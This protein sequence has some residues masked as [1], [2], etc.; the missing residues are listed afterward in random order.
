MIIEIQV[1]P[2]PGGTSD[3]R[4][5]NVHA[6]ITV[7]EE[8]GLHYEVGPLG[9]SIEGSPDELWPLLRKVHEAPLEAGAQGCISVVKIA[10]HHDDDAPTM[11]SLTDR[12]RS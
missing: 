12:Y 10:E 9:T 4:F 7:I 8:S 3:E 1:L 2:S 5:S 6:A 11:T